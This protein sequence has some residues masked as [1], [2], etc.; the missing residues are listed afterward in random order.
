MNKIRR[1]ISAIIF[2]EDN[3]GKKKF[4]L[5]KRKQNWK[6]WEFLKGGRKKGEDE[7]AALKREIK[8]ETGLGRFSAKKTRF[9]QEF[10]YKKEYKKDNKK[11]D[12]AR[13]RIFLVEVFDKKIKT[14]KIEHSGFKW[15]SKK[16][17]LKMLTW[18]DYRRIFRQ[19]KI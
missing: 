6:G 19:I 3:E 16:E 10:N 7:W 13:N 15:A 17:A 1:G 9:I 12:G 5:L 8:E 2:F 14:D 11:W 18:K 4:L